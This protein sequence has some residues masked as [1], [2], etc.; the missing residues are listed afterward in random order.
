MSNALLQDI[1]TDLKML[2]ATLYVIMNI[3][4]LTHTQTFR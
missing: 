3:Y 1:Y 4:I 2:K